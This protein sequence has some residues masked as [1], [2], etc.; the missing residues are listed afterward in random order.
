MDLLV[1]R[2]QPLIK[3]TVES[4]KSRP[5]RLSQDKPHA[6]PPTNPP[7]SHL[8]RKRVQRHAFP[9]LQLVFKPVFYQYPMNQIMRTEKKETT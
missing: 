1:E 6:A 7:E 8:E 5:L 9:L 4:P 2:A 3:Q